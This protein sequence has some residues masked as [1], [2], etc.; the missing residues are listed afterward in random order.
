[1]FIVRDKMPSFEE[2]AGHV[3]NSVIPI[4]IGTTTDGL[5]NIIG[6]GFAVEFSEFFVTCCHIAQTEDE[7]GKLSKQKLENL[8]LK[9]TKLR[10]GLFKNGDYTWHES[11]AKTWLRVIS[12]ELDICVYRVIGVA[13]PPLHL[14]TEEGFPW[15][16]E[17]GVI[18]F[19]MGN[20]LQS[21]KFRPFVAKTIIAGGLEQKL[22]GEKSVQKLALGS[23]FAGGFSGGPVFSTTDGQILGMVASKVL[24]PGNQGIVWPAGISLAVTP[25]DIRNGLN[26]CISV[27][28]KII[29]DSLRK[30]LP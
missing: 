18:G 21:K 27:S 28:T 3:V 1:M 25:A 15:A 4:A 6:A 10:I 2:V 5:P 16:A 8:G 24:E 17:V 29:E 12:Q 14:W 23:A 22:E 9:D 20:K 30:H 13:I 19:P 11:E 26:S 7:L